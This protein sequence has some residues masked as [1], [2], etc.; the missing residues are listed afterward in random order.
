MF[1]QHP[2][3]CRPPILLVG[4]ISH[5]SYIAFACPARLTATEPHGGPLSA[6][7]PPLERPSREDGERR[8]LAEPGP[9]II[10]Q[11]R[12]AI[13]CVDRP[14][15]T[16]CRHSGRRGGN[17]RSKSLAAVRSRGS[18]ATVKCCR[19]V[20]APISVIAS[21]LS[22]NGECFAQRDQRNPNDPIER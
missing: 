7:K 19:F 2:A 9:T 3:V 12:T 18:M 4:F 20:S 1:G 17:D 15:A 6:T 13:A 5:L 11:D 8:Q 10:L 16:P 14:F 22:E 21:L